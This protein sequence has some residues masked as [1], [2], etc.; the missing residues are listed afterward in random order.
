MASSA[1]S[2]AVNAVML[3]TQAG[4]VPEGSK[5]VLGYD[6]NQGIDYDKLLGSMIFT[7]FQ[8][9]HFGQAVEQVNKMLHWR[10]SDEPIAE[11][12]DEALRSPEARQ[13]VK[14]KIF[15]GYTSNMISCGVRESIRFLVQHKMVDVIVSTAGG[16]EEDFIKCLAPTYVGSFNL[17][18]A[19]LRRQGL[20]RIG[21]L[22]VANDN[23]CKFED[24]IMPILDQML[25]E[26]ISNGTIWSPSKIIA[27]LGREIGRHPRCEESVYY[28]AYKNNIPIFCPALTDGSIGDMIYFHS[29]KRSNPSLIIDIASDI[30][31][32]NQQA[33]YA[34][35]TGM[36]IL[37]GGLVKH[38]INN[39]NLMRNGADHVVLIN[40]A[41]EF[42]G[43]DSGASTDEVRYFVP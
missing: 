39:A 33:V 2:A 16:V 29:F 14:C 27:R 38:H 37:G 41:H 36:I 18:G 17:P 43:S 31:E 21:N 20:N 1:P 35:K 8:A 23:Y 9:T 13:A 25:E 11:D 7:G 28:W 3:P 42:D 22:F 5:V 34:K 40:T 24:W 19:D 12:E 32:I 26:Q 6:F 10:L 4:A 30:R 15:F